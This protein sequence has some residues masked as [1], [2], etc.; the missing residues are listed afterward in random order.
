MRKL[1][2]RFLMRKVWEGDIGRLHEILTVLHS[3]SLC[4][5]LHPIYLRRYLSSR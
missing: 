2:P 4:N 1:K 5:Y 3:K